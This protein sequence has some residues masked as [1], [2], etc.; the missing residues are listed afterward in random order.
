MTYETVLFEKREGIAY[1]TLHRP[2]RANA[3]NA[4]LASEMNDVL[5]E[6]A[7]DPE[8]RVVILTG[9]GKHFCGGADLREIRG[10]AAFRG[11]RDFISHIEEVDV[12]VIAAINGA[13]M[14]GG[15]EIA[16]ACDIRIM[17]DTAQMGLPEIRFGALPMA[18]GTQRLPRL[19]GSGFAKEV[20]FSGLPLSAD[21][22]L[23]IG[24]VNRV[25]P[26][27]DLLGA[28]EAM[29]RVFIER[30][31]YALAAAKFLT[32]QAME[33]DLHTGLR[34]ERRVIAKMA[35]AEERTAAMQRAAA[36]QAT[37]AN[38]FRQGQRE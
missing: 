9:A 3:I 1:V 29:A 27:A 11:G 36:S 10:L 7:A 20:I 2:D 34:M 33:V 6:V 23:R 24:M 17:A 35:T 31:A 16:L 5:D 25:V 18:G 37:Y 28:C 4:Q 32:N 22:A 26:A 21:E 15:C 12:P 30:A 13:A 19:V 14:G 8:L 38:I